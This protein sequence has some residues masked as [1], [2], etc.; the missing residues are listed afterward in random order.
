[1]KIPCVHNIELTSK[2]E[3]ISSTPEAL[4]VEISEIIKNDVSNSCL[5]L[6]DINSNPCNQVLVKNVIVETCSDKIAMET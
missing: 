2:L 5:Y 4:L 3:N 6:I 1:M